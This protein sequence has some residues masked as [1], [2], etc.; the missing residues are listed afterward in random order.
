[1]AGLH[2][3]LADAG[4]TLA[5]SAQSG[6]AAGRID[7]VIAGI[8][9]RRQPFAMLHEVDPATPAIMLVDHNSWNGLDFFDAANE[10][11]AVAVLQR[12]FTR[13]ALLHLIAGVLS[14]SVTKAA[15]IEPSCEEQSNLTE[16][17]FSLENPNLA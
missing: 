2:T 13:S 7:L 16:L 6:D 1:R 15:E 14:D 11:G 10:L 3:L 17:L 5:E 9:A 4:Y 12:P 8:G